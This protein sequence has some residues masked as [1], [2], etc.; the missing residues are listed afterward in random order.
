MWEPDG[1][2]RGLN[3]IS[4]EQLDAVLIP[5]LR[6]RGPLDAVAITGGEPLMQAPFLADWLRRLPPNLPILLETNGV[7]PAALERVIDWV[8]VVS[9]DVKLP[10]NS[11]EPAFWDEH[12]DFVEVAR[13]KQLYVKILVDSSTAGDEFDRAVD[14]LAGVAA[15]VPLFVQ[16]IVDAEGALQASEDDLERFYSA[17]RR[18]L[19]QVRML[20]QIHKFLGIR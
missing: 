19:S 4:P 17:A 15:G 6:R 13:R 11:G 3:P 18:G 20:P 14:M 8:D 1:S 2:L 7:L 9:M 10:S 5:F 12:R 16:P